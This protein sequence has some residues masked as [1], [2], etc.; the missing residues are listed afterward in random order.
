M[1]E[2]NKFFGV[3]LAAFLMVICMQSLWAESQIEP[4]D[5]PL[6]V[7]N[8]G[9]RG[10]QFRPKVISSAMVLSVAKPDGTVF[11]QTFRG[12][13]TPYFELSADCM[14]GSYT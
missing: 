10:I 6:A 1:G 11:Q 14:D 8:I 5:E 3:I 7:L 9:T 12:S 4:V 13:D 2:R